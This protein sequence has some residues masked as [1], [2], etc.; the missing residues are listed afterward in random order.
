[1]AKAAKTTVNTASLV[2]AKMLGVVVENATDK[3]IAALLTSAG[4]TVAG[5]KVV[6]ADKG[7]KGKK[8]K[9]PTVAEIVAAVKDEEELD[10]SGVDEDTLRQAVVKAKLSTAKKA[11]ALDEDELREL[12]NEKLGGESDEDEDEED[13][14]EDSDDEDE[15]EDDSDDEDEDEDEDEDDEDDDSDDEDEDEDDEDEDDEDEDED[16]DD[17]LDLDSLDEDELRALVL[18]EKLATA[19]KAK[20]MDEDELRELLE[21]HFGG[22]DEDEDEDEDEDDEDFDDEDEDE[23]DE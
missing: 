14:D 9:A 6:K 11:K 19:K 22:D 12:L 2:L 16:E 1:M 10:I 3:E 17:E 13:E 5:G 18:K 8:A 15:D 23:D 20:K 21:E 7:G 4:L